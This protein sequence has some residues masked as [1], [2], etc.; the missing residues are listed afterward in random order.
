MQTTGHN[1]SPP[2]AW[3]VTGPTSGIG[4]RTALETATHRTVVLVGRDPS[5]LEELEGESGSHLRDGP[6]RSVRV[7]RGA[8]PSTP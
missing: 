6:P 1:G 4:R 5:K 2:R 3:I 7:H 8:D